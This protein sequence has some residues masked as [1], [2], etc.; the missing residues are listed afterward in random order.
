LFCL[1]TWHKRKQL[2]SVK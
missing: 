1:L 2:S